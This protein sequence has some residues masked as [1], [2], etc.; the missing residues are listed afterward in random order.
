MTTLGSDAGILRR[1]RLFAVL[2]GRRPSICVVAAPSGFG[3]TTLVRDWVDSDADVTG[4]ARTIW[5]PFVGGVPS[6]SAFWEAVASAADRAGACVGLTAEVSNYPGESAGLVRAVARALPNS[7]RVVL[8]AYENVGSLAH[9]IDDDL[10]LLT[11]HAPDVQIVVTT[12][13]VG[14]WAE[15]TRLLR[16]QVRLVTENDLAFTREEVA[17]LLARS[18]SV[19]S[20]ERVWATTRGYPLAVR[21]VLLSLRGTGGV[22]P[23]QIAYEGDV[24]SWSGLVAENLRA[25][26]ADPDLRNFVRM[27]AIPPFFDSELA[28]MLSPNQPNMAALKSMISTL[29]AEGLGR[30]IPFAA[31]REVFQ[32]VES[33]RHVMVADA[34]QG[35]LDSSQLVRAADLSS[36][37]LLQNGL[38]EQ[39]LSFAI[40]ARN[41]DRVES[42]TT[43]L[44][45]TVPETYITNRLVPVLSRLPSREFS[46]Y[47]VVAFALAL[48]Y[49]TDPLMRGSARELFEIVNAKLDLE[50]PSATERL[51]RAGVLCVSQR[52][53]GSFEAA[54]VSALR[55]WDIF[56]GLSLSDRDG[57]GTL[58][59]VALRN[60][61]YSL[62][63]AGDL[64]KASE[65]IRSTLALTSTA[66]ERNYTL[67]FASGIDALQ[68]RNELAAEAIS[69]IDSAAWPSQHDDSYMS[70]LGQ[71]GE[72]FLRLDNLDWEGVVSVFTA[73]S[74][75]LQTAEFWP[76]VTVAL[77]RARLA[78][79]KAWTEVRRVQDILA[80]TPVPPGVGVNHGTAML[81]NELA[82]LWLSLGE[83]IRA[84]TAVESFGRPHSQL[85]PVKT[86]L[87]LLRDDP[88]SALMEAAES[89]KLPGHTIRSRAAIATISAAAAARAGHDALALSKLAEIHSLF[90]VHGVRAQLIL[91]PED[92]RA[93]LRVIAKH[94]EMNLE[95]FLPA[96]LATPFLS[97]PGAVVLTNREHH[98]L[99]V[100]AARAS[101]ISVPTTADIAAQ[102]FISTNTLKT[103]LQGIYRKLGAESRET[104]I[105][106]AHELGLL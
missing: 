69:R 68:G 29:Q 36:K 42:I 93:R 100:L 37:W 102:L 57:L 99:R 8:D 88:Q 91:L 51:F 78:Q 52:L 66:A 65:V 97:L 48:A 5:V 9:Q 45:L 75:L 30:L 77:M 24:G 35:G 94:H 103:Q 2:D 61:S 32:Y 19:E 13:S 90:E 101:S 82:L 43:D 59:P 21:A 63:Q 92:D 72:A 26:L 71:V 86:L 10:V 23:S 54:G 47:P 56:L 105:I 15:P 70:L 20:A 53:S 3:K 46:R 22:A 41:F 83:V 25:Q 17:A 4:T 74:V 44:L 96:S 80:V 12:R 50:G 39:A 14:S 84:R 11:S 55:T 1:D 73:D 98:V 28:E 58:A 40:D 81:H 95:D 33:F 16:N 104:A 79:G 76:F 67:A 34:R 89:L 87:P 106:R 31:G 49:L 64:A 85:G 27:T 62:L 60:V 18:A 38:L 6:R 7:A